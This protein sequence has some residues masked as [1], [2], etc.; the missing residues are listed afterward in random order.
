MPTPTEML[1]TTAAIVHT[2]AA[3]TPFA[4]SRPISIEEV[5]LSPPGP[6]EVLVRVLA[7]GL[8][9]S[10][11]SR[12]SGKRPMDVPFVPGHEGAGLVEAIGSEVNDVD[13]GDHVVF[14]YSWS[15]GRCERCLGGRPQICL[16]AGESKAKG[17]MPAG[18]FR[19]RWNG[20]AVRH[21]AGVSCF[22]RHAVLDRGS[23]VPID[24]AVPVE[25]AAL[26]GCALTTGIGAVVNA[27][28]VELGSSVAVF[29][30]GGVGLSAVLGARLRGAADIVAVDFNAAKLDA[31]RKLGATVCIDAGT[32]DVEGRI[33][34]AVGAVDFAIE[35]AGAAAAVENAVSVTRR[36]G[37][38]VVAGLAS[39][40][41]AIALRP[42]ALV[43]EEQEVVGCYMGSSVVARDIPRM[44]RLFLRREISV[45]ALIDRKIPLEGLNEGFDRLRDGRAIRQIVVPGEPAP[46]A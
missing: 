4:D 17:T 30:L 27:A 11:L 23:V 14:A 39:A 19:I 35:A 40:D 3:E 6:T 28:K 32:E 12:L 10:D 44:A 33:R 25:L 8:C 16:R 45:D 43:S 18:G 36:G 26:F 41:T 21:Y 46:A 9:Q 24:K 20:A 22:A 15:C 2:C 38:I 5:E 29:G 1:R 31:A 13:V 37:R 42:A 7:A 34:D